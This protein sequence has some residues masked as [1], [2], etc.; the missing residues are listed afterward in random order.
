MRALL[1]F[2]LFGQF[3][4]CAQG[5]TVTGS[6]DDA[7]D[8][9]STA[10]GNGAN[11]P[12]GSDT[13]GEG[14]S[15]ICADG[16]I[17]SGEDCDGTNLGGATCTSLGMGFS[18]GSLSCSNS[19]R[20]DTSSCTSSQS[21]GNTVIDAGEV[22]D[23]GNLAGET[24]ATQGF[25]GGTL[26]CNGSCTGFDT[27]GCSDSCTSTN[28]FATNGGFESGPGAPQW[29]EAS[30]AFGTPICDGTCGTVNGVGSQTGT[31]WV[32]IGGT[33]TADE[34]AYVARTVTI[35]PG[36]ATLKFQFALPN[37]EDP[38][39]ATDRFAASI[40]GTLVFGID[41]SS[42]TCGTGY[43]LRE[44][45]VSQFADGGSHTVLFEGE[46]FDFELPTSFFVDNVELVSCQ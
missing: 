23:G 20:F 7:A 6:G 32:W 13:G 34:Y 10:D 19:C 11:A 39:I 40:D 38:G 25:D 46:T 4:A 14:P 17:N 12:G 36:T 18:G 24:C 33:V 2:A 44:F 5:G 41:N 35:P 42:T 29:E 30:Q 28:L 22:C 45:D 3:A 27:A 21:C 1:A 8:G 26:A 43:T 37:C 31:Y 9:G 15:G 16:Q